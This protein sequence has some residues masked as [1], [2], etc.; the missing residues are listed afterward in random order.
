M[1]TAALVRTKKW[2]TPKCASAGGEATCGTVTHVSVLFGHKKERSPDTRS[3]GGD[4]ESIVPNERSV[5]KGHCRIM[6]RT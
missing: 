4:S 5:T 1:F 3:D 2:K 6:P